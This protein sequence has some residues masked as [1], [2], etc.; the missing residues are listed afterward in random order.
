MHTHTTHVHTHTHTYNTCSRTLARMRT[1][2]LPLLPQ[3]AFLTGTAL[4]HL[5]DAQK[6]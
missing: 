2:T 4:S 5:P 6:S 3:K 1:H